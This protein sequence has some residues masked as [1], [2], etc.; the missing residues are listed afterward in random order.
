MWAGT[1]TF[2]CKGEYVLIEIISL[3]MYK[4][5]TNCS[6]GALCSTRDQISSQW[7]ESKS[8]LYVWDERTEGDFSYLSD[9]L[10]ALLQH[11]KR[12][13]LRCIHHFES[14]L[15]NNH[16]RISG[17]GPSSVILSPTK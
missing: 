17:T 6:H 15:N 14:D 2:L 13:L 3:K 8:K 1:K 10:L 16:M 5:Q 7:T 9:T 11:K 4:M 12:L